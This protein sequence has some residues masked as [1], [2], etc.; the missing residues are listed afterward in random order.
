MNTAR[1][2]YHQGHFHRSVAVTHN[3][4]GMDKHL[5]KASVLSRPFPWLLWLFSPPSFLT[6]VNPVGLFLSFFFLTITCLILCALASDPLKLELQTVISYYAGTEPSLQP[7]VGLFQKLSMAKQS[8]CSLNILVLQPGPGLELAV[9]L[10]V[11]LPPRCPLSAQIS[12]SVLPRGRRK[13]RGQSAMERLNLWPFPSLPF[14]FALTLR[15]GQAGA[16]FLSI[17]NAW[18]ASRDSADSNFTAV[19]RWCYITLRKGF[20]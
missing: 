10:S 9:W 13:R 4:A 1:C 20:G 15:Q 6:P 5:V 3:C 8:W 7:R 19:G 2:D 17:S 18:S 11:P 16:G 14:S 12:M